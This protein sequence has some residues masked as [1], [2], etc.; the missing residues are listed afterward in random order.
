MINVYNMEKKLLTKQS[1]SEIK[2]LAV[3]DNSDQYLWG[4]L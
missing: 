1:K 2:K 4:G 3:D